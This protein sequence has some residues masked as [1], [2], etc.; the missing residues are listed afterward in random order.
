MH[1][2]LSPS[3]HVGAQIY[4]EIESSLSNQNA[5]AATKFGW[6]INRYTI[7]GY[8]WCNLRTLESTVGERCVQQALCAFLAHFTQLPY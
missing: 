2:I 8:S 5:D 6:D 1:T 7:N 4:F 3:C